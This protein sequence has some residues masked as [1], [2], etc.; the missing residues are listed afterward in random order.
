MTAK[1]NKQFLRLL[2]E[3]QGQFQLQVNVIAD[4]IRAEVIMP[5]C[6]KHKLTF[7]SDNGDFWFTDKRNVDYR[8]DDPN[9]YPWDGASYIQ[10]AV[11][12]ILRLL[13]EEVAYA[14]CLGFYVEGVKL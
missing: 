7:W 3:A 2:K 10:R 12:P 9:E 14:K 4:A 5:V 11:A 8:F 1:Q 13:N 6:Q